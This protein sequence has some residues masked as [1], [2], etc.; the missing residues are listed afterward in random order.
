MRSCVSVIAQ[1]NRHGTLAFGKASPHNA[2]F[3][4]IQ[5]EMAAK[6]MLS[7]LHTFLNAILESEY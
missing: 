6:K 7:Q 4:F 5:P 2:A 3:A 1:K